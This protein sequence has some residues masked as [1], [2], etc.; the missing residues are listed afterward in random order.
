MEWKQFH[1]IL[2]SISFSFHLYFQE[3]CTFSQ[4]SGREINETVPF[5]IKIQ[6]MRIKI[7]FVDEKK[8][9]SLASSEYNTVF[10]ARFKQFGITLLAFLPHKVLAVPSVFFII[11]VWVRISEWTLIRW[12]WKKQI[13]SFSLSSGKE[14]SKIR[15][16]NE[17]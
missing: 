17:I 15:Y 9:I 5:L 16:I 8:T 14:I 13:I 12:N 7:Y 2:Y 6:V 10:H 3:C 4:L 11:S 1:N